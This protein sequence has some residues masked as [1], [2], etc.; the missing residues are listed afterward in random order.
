VLGELATV[1]A[2]DPVLAWDYRGRAVRG[3]LLE[4]TGNMSAMRRSYQP[5]AERRLGIPDAGI[6]DRG[7][8]TAELP[9][10]GDVT[11]TQGGPR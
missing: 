4:L 9:H 1:A 6:S 10:Y 3:H 7:Q 2:G 11:R 5:A 8:P